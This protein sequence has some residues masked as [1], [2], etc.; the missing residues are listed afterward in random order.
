MLSSPPTMTIV[1]HVHV[2]DL[3][4]PMIKND[5]DVHGSIL[6]DHCWWCDAAAAVV[7]PINAGEDRNAKKAI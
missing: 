4:L 5:K 7:A 2:G 6:C 3:M 1:V